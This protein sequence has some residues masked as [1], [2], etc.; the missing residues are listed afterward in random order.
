[1][2]SYSRSDS[3]FSLLE[4]LIVLVILGFMAALIPPRLSGVMLSTQAK[5]SA[6]DIVSALR[7]T[8][9]TAIS[10]GQEQI[11]RLDLTKKSFTINH[12]TRKNLPDKMQISLYTARSEQLSEQEGAIRFYP[13]GSS[14]GGR[15]RLIM[16][17]QQLYV[18]VN[19]LTGKVALL[20]NVDPDHW[21]T[22][23]SHYTLTNQAE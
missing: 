10:T 23:D 9:T 1:M 4:L 15:I 7:Q 17:K 14:T 12:T 18:D 19:W 11:F 13:D 3:G 16:G 6:R 22:G 20:D 21:N 8:R 5:A 2:L